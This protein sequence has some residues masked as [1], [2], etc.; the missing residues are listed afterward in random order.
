MADENN[1]GAGATGT[2]N[3]NES[4][5]ASDAKNGNEVQLTEEQ[6]AAAFKH[7]RFKELTSQAQELKTLKAQEQA[8]AEE[9]AKKKGEFEKLFNDQKKANETLRMDNAITLAAGKVGAVDAEAI[10]K[11][12]D[13]SKLKIDESGQVVGV[14]EAVKALLESKPYLAG[15]GGSLGNGTSPGDGDAGTGTKKFKLSQIQNAEFWKK[16]EKDILEAIKHNQI[17]QDI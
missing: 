16:N 17:E 3:N 4:S 13:R 15:K 14:E 9:E 1:A 8:R 12:V 10:L 6:L 11:L 2:E 5:N 7:P